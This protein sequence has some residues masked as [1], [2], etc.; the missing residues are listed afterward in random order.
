[1]CVHELLLSLGVYVYMCIH[2]CKFIVT[3]CN[4]DR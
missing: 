2:M 1:M 4:Q 3:D